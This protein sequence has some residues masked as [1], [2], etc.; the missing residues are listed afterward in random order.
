MLGQKSFWS[1]LGQWSFKK[2]F[3]WDF[4]TFRKYIFLAPTYFWDKE[5]SK[6]FFEII[7][8]G[9]IFVTLF[10]FL[11]QKHWPQ[12]SKKKFSISHYLSKLKKM[13]NHLQTI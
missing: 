11:R 4:L 8:P 1:L 6:S 9:P 10:L 13:D 12:R 2:K 5:K 3:F 7:V